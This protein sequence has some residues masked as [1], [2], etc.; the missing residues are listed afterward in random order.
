MHAIPSVLTKCPPPRSYKVR[1]CFA[2]EQGNKLIV[3]DY[4]QLEL[5]LLAHMSR[6]RSM[7]DAFSTGGDFHSRT[8][9]GMYPE[10]AREVESGELL[11]EW[12]SAQGEAPPVPLLKDKYAMERRRAKT[13]NFSIAYGKTARGLA[14]DW[15]TSVKEAQETLER[16]YADRPEVRQWQEDTVRRARLTGYTKTLMGRYRV[17]PGIQRGRRA[18]HMARAAINTPLQVSA[19]DVAEARFCLCSDSHCARRAVRPIL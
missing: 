15:E 12:D 14:I 1:G 10:I 7:L 5:R 8:A 9:Q 4:G 17:L 18:A 16:W 6:C 11:L 13:L 19:L 2:A 3:A